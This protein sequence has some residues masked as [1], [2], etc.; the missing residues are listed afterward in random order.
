MGPGAPGWALARNR[1]TCYSRDLGQTESIRPQLCIC[2]GAKGIDVALL[3]APFQQLVVGVTAAE[4]QSGS[5]PP[6]CPVSKTSPTASHH[7]LRLPAA[8]HF[9][10]H[11][12]P[13]ATPRHSAMRH[14]APQHAAHVPELDTKHRQ[15]CGVPM[16]YLIGYW[17]LANFYI[18]MVSWGRPG[19]PACRARATQAAQALG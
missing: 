15:G 7:I 10:P 6:Q 2:T 5:L 3:A 14:R 12:Q 13:L 1:F 17:M 16:L 11:D 9:T 18:A 4:V 8:L 19:H